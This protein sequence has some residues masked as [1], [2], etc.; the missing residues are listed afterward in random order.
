MRERSKRE[1]AAIVDARLECSRR[2]ADL[3]AQAAAEGKLL[4]SPFLQ[5]ADEWKADVTQKMTAAK[6]VKTGVAGM[7]GNMTGLFRRSP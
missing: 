1:R 2:V 3:Y 5:K 6:A 7:L 4:V